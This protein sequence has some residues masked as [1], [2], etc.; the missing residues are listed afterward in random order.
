MVNEGIRS[1]RFLTVYAEGFARKIA[2][3]ATRFSYHQCA[4]GGVPWLEFQFPKS[5]ESA[6]SD[7]AY[8]QGCGA[9]RRIL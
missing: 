9:P 2:Q 7:V 8:I 6:A 5:I 4:G 1:K 3:N